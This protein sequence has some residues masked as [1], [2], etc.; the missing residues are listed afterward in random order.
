MLQKNPSLDGGA[1]PARSK[2][3]GFLLAPA[4]QVGIYNNAL[5]RG[6]VWCDRLALNGR[7]ATLEVTL[8]LGAP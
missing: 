8:G 7:N 6:T 5:V 1:P 4:S 2:L 3:F